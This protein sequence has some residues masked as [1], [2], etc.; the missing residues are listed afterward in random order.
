[1]PGSKCVAVGC[2]SSRKHKLPLL[3]IPKS[4]FISYL[5]VPKPILGKWRGR[6]LNPPMIVTVNH[7]EP[8]DKVGSHS[9][10]ENIPEIRTEN[11][12]ILSWWEVSHFSQRLG[13]Y[14]RMEKQISR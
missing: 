13:I 5:R 1:M 2:S 7:Q 6:S 9:L 10:A 4:V 8:C 11:L 12:P 14:Y 3:Q